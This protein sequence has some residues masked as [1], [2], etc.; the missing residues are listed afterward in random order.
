MQL[1]HIEAN[2]DVWDGQRY[3]MLGVR[4]KNRWVLLQ[5]YEAQNVGLSP[6][7]RGNLEYQTETT[8]AD[9]CKD[10]HEMIEIIQRV[11]NHYLPDHYQLYH[12]CGTAP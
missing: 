2:L 9:L 8:L 7:E 3:Q 6:T 5:K 11:T 10:F 12:Q 1:A 4:T